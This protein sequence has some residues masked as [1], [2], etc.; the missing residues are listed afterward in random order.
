MTKRGLLLLLLTTF[1]SCS[2]KGDLVDK[3]KLIGRFVFQIANH[4]TLDVNSNGTYSYYKWWYG[5]KLENTGTWTYDS[6]S[7]RVDFQ[8]FSF[9][10]DTIGIADSTFV[11]SGHWTT[12]IETKDN[13]IHF[14]Y[15]SDVYKGYF[16]KVDSVDRKK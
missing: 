14:I 9:L 12:K 3:D 10:T 1:I 5:R 2:D 11:P 15:A 13:E 6:L 7:G 4:D 8:K 16:L